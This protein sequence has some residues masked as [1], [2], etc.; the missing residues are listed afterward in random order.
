MSKNSFY[1]LLQKNSGRLERYNAHEGEKQLRTYPNHYKVIES[2]QKATE[3]VKK[4]GKKK[5]GG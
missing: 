2:P 3:G 1:I 5:G 4:T